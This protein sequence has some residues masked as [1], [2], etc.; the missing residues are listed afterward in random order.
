MMI[1]LFV[2][3]NELSKEFSLLSGDR[4]D[5]I[6]AWNISEI[7]QENHIKFLIFMMMLSSR[8]KCT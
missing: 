3:I 2:G 4:E 5:A 1:P 6:F 8:R 7:P